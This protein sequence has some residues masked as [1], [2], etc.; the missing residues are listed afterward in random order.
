MSTGG[1][2]NDDARP[3]AAKV[4][5]LPEQIA[6][7]LGSA[8]ARGEFKSGERLRETEIATR[9]GVSRGPV[10]E[11][12]RALAQRGLA[13]FEPRRGAHVV[14]LDLH[15]VI[16]LFNTRAVLLGLAARYF[17]AVGTSEAKS[18][19]AQA[20][21]RLAAL[22]AAADTDPIR[23][24]TAAGGIGV[25]IARNCGSRSLGSL[26]EHQIDASAWG[27]LWRHEP[28]DYMTRERRLAATAD[29]SELCRAIDERKGERAEKVMRRI[30][31]RAQENAVATL[32]LLRGEDFDER[33]L[34]SA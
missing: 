31:V 7:D 22:G 29:Y 2:L 4:R 12:I 3:A 18:S 19:L 30:M 5:T 16:D 34:L 11:A 20:M 21:Q 9:Y 1:P 13:V 14:E 24:A 8:I 23:F 28:L 25:V 17:A 27:T 32:S 10:R 6:D 33:R 15:A 26:I